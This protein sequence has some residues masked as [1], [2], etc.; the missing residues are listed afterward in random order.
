MPLYIAPIGQIG[1][2]LLLPQQVG[3][4]FQGRVLRPCGI[5][6]ER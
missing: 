1:W 2:Q 3:R 6:T 4:P 5:G